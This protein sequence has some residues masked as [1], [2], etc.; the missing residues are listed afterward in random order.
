MI[1][2]CANSVQEG[3]KTV[4]LG[5]QRASIKIKVKSVLYLPAT[6]DFDGIQHGVR[7]SAFTCSW[8]MKWFSVWELMRHY[9]PGNLT[10]REKYLAF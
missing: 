4:Y 10:L 9:L 6:S 3:E 7:R 1:S 2:C 5:N 8:R